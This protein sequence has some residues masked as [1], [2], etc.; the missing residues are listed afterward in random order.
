[1]QIQHEQGI[2]YSGN[3]SFISQ[4]LF[5]F[6]LAILASAAGTWLGFE[7]MA[8]YLLA[9]P[10]LMYLLFALE[11]LLIFTSGLWSHRRPLNYILFVA[12]ALITGLTLFPILALFAAEMGAAII[13]KALL[14]TTLMFSA[15]AV[16]GWVTNINLSGLRGFLWVGL[17]GLLITGILGIFIPWSNQIEMIYAGIGTIIFGAYT[18]YD[19][20]QLRHAPHMNPIDAALRLYLDIFNL[21]LFILRLMG[22][23]GRD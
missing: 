18:M 3:P 1:M 7:Y 20:Q 11:L 8:P 16:F 14:A 17:I 10:W 2:I 5:Y 6:G 23:V 4:T 13:V 12:F 19:I 15:A 22:A 21:F 9:A